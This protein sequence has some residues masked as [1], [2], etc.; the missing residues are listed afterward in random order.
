MNFKLLLFIAATL[1]ASAW[2]ISFGSAPEMTKYTTSCM[3]ENRIS[4]LTVRKLKNGDLSVNDK[5]SQCFIKCLLEK[6]GLIE[7]GEFLTGNSSKIIELSNG[8]EKILRIHEICKFFFL[9]LSSMRRVIEICKDI[10]GIDD[11]ETAF[12]LF[13]C[14]MDNKSL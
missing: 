7:D 3:I 5:K 14:Y 6:V 4:P 1:I 10:K 11:C 8:N 13:E 12:L 9:V 2:S